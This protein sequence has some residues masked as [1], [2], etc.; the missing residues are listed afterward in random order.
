MKTAESDSAYRLV[1]ICKNKKKNTLN[2]DQL[3]RRYMRNKLR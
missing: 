3:S 1:C 2:I